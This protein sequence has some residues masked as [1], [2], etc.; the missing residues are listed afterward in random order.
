MFAVVSRCLTHSLFFISFITAEDAV[1][2]AV[3]YNDDQEGD[4]VLLFT[5]VPTMMFSNNNILRFQ[6]FAWVKAN[7]TA[8]R[9][10]TPS[11]RYGLGSDMLP[12]RP[13]S[14]TTRSCEVSLDT[15]PTYHCVGFGPAFTPTLIRN[16]GPAHP[17][18]IRIIGDIFQIAILH[19]QRRTRHIHVTLEE[20][21]PL[22]PGDGHHDA[23]DGA[24]G[25]PPEDPQGGQ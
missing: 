7:I 14:P 15:A 2:A 17:R 12:P 13:V 1:R 5:N 10:V 9:S 21:E 20:W 3:W 22:Y 19:R 4:N 25:G 8:T 16:D 6:D 11:W 18:S 23:H 24:N